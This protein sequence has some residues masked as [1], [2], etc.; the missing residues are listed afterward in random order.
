MIGYICFYETARV[1]SVSEKDVTSSVLMF[2]SV[3]LCFKV[4]KAIGHICLTDVVHLYSIKTIFKNC[5]HLKIKGPIKF[6][7]FAIS[8]KIGKIWQI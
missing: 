3:T 4:F 6:Q 5:Q 2:C 8:G 1:T 7:I